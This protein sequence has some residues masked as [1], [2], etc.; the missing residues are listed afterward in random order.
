MCNLTKQNICA[1]LGSLSAGF[2]CAARCQAACPNWAAVPAWNVVYYTATRLERRKERRYAAYTF[3]SSGAC[4]LPY[5]QSPIQD[6]VIWTFSKTTVCEKTGEEAFSLSS[7]IAV[8][9]ASL[10]LKPAQLLITHKAVCN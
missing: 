7:H 4:V 1:K 2:S 9:D 5:K 10:V 3:G 8:W 6:T